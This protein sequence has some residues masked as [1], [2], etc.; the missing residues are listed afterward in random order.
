MLFHPLFNLEDLRD[1]R[2]KAAHDLLDKYMALEALGP[3][4]EDSDGWRETSVK[5]KLPA[6][7]HQTRIG[8]EAEAPELEIKG[9]HHRPIMQTIYAALDTPDTP[10]FH[11]T[12]FREYHGNERIYCELYSADAWL[13]AHEEVR[14]L[15]KEDN[16]ENFV[17]PLLLYS[18]ST[19]LSSFGTASLWPL[20]MYLGSQSKY[21]RCRTTESTCHH[22]AYIP[23]VCISFSFINWSN[24]L[25]LIIIKLISASCLNLG[26]L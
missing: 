7:D 1:Y 2:T 23:S 3:N 25:I 24:N 15:P 13:E 6:E 14:A 26:R 21:M 18:D 17:L 19:H 10:A 9:I 8:G 20:Y 11:H 5:L 16:I 4:F 22:L 12:P